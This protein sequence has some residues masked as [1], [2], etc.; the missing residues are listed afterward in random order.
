MRVNDLFLEEGVIKC[1]LKNQT[2]ADLFE[3]WKTYEYCLKKKIDDQT[4]II[5]RVASK[6]YGS[7]RVTVKHKSTEQKIYFQIRP[8][9]RSYFLFVYIPFAIIVFLSN[10]QLSSTYWI[11]PPTIFFLL[12][13]LFFST[14]KNGKTEVIKEFR[15]M[16][17][18]R[19]I[20]NS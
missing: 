6:T 15:A 9:V 1:N 16:L 12:I 8:R 2:L 11:L 5:Y 3:N 4:I 14:T 19:G 13:L 7:Y 18:I 17:L 10:E 20:A